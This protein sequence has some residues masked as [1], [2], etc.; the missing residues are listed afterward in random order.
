MPAY[1]RW[2]RTTP[3]LL[4]RLSGNSHPDRSNGGIEDFFLTPQRYLETVRRDLLWLLKTETACPSTVQLGD[5]LAQFPRGSRDKRPLD[6]DLLTTLADFPNA[7]SSVIAFGVPAFTGSAGSRSAAQQ[8]ERAIEK[9]IR[10]FEQRI[11]RRTL[12]VKL[13]P[14]LEA[15]NAGNTV[16]TF[17]FEIEV[18]ICMKP[19]TEH[20]QFKAYYTPAFSQWRIEGGSNGS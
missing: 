13:T 17:G 12:R 2:D 16:S 10:Q 8:L 6:E 18:D 5:P 15:A 9:S 4:D 7:S 20:L 14:Q 11:D 1:S 19:Q 3:S